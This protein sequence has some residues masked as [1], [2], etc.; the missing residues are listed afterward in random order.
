MTEIRHPSAPS[1]RIILL[2]GGPP[3][4]LLKLFKED[5][6]EAR[7][8][9]YHPSGQALLILGG[10]RLTART[11]V[12]LPVGRTVTL[13]VEEVS[14]VLLLRLLGIKP[15]SSHS[16]N[17]PAILYAME[18]NLW[19]AVSLRERGFSVFG[20]EASLLRELMR[21]WPSRSMAGSRAA[22]LKAWIEKTGLSWEAKLRRSLTHRSL[23][24]Q[25]LGKLI[26]GDLKGQISKL[27]GSGAE[28]TDLLKRLASAIDH[29][30]LL[31]HRAFTQKGKIFIPIPYEFPNGETGVAQLILHIPRREENEAGRQSKRESTSHVTFLVHMSALGFIRADVTVVEKRIRGTFVS[32][33][34]ET[35]VLMEN[36]LPSLVSILIEKGFFIDQMECFVGDPAKLKQIITKEI[37]EEESQL[38]LVA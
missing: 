16:V 4:P 25:E 1:S 35:R 12:P 31:N 18:E 14:P 7:V 10:R 34:E 9:E 11:R 38:N 22:S 30:Q 28:D 32:G 20:K 19:K 2:E 3:N 27:L 8:A 24:K 17:L 6:M 29:I 36:H 15:A 23:G 37:L 33:R 21:G 5:V 26:E 13:K